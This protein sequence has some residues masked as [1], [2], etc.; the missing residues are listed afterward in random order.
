MLIGQ[1]HGVMLCQLSHAPPACMQVRAAAWAD[2]R[3][4]QG[5]KDIF[6]L[7]AFLARFMLLCVAWRG[8]WWREVAWRGVA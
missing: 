4:Q 8:V 5:D 3:L 7:E 1:H 2:L 6:H